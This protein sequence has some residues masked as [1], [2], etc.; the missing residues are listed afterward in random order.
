M[1]ERNPEKPPTRGPEHERLEPF[2]GKWHTEGQNKAAAPGA[3]NTPV[4]GEESYEWLPGGFFLVNR[5]DRRFG[6]AEHKGI[7]IVAFDAATGEYSTRA[8]D[9][10]GYAREYKTTLRDRTMALTGKWERATLAVSADGQTMTIH[11]E[12]SEDGEHWLPLCDLVATR[13]S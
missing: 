12:R 3:A 6:G 7:G 9:N 8:F 5:W 11:W 2:V 4:T 1:T 13:A 10:L